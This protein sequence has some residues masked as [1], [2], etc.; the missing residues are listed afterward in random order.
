MCKMSNGKEIQL[1]ICIT[2]YNRIHELERC[3]LSIDAEPTYNVEVI[4]SED[5]S[6]K[7]EE[8]RNIVDN[9]A[10]S[11]SYRVIYNSNPHNLGYDRNLAKLISLASGEF[12]LLMSDDDSFVK[13]SLNSC[14]K[15]ISQF[16]SNVCMAYTY[17]VY[18]G[19]DGYGRKHRGDM[20]ID[21]G[22][23]SCCKYVYDAILFSGLIFRNNAINNFDAERFL[24]V[25]YFQV[26]LFLSCMLIHQT[27]YIDC[28]LVSC[29]G[30]G[31]NAYGNVESSKDEK[32]RQKL[33]DRK[34]VVSN[35]YFNKGLIHAIEEFD[36]ENKTD[37]LDSFEKEYSIHSY[38]GLSIA[39]DNGIACLDEYWLAMKQLN[40]HIHWQAKVYYCVLRVLGRRFSDT[41][42]GGLRK[43]ALWIR[44]SK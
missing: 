22:L 19:S 4:V 42:F 29:N 36:K 18:L 40:I 30:D 39:R 31:E 21:K 37:L 23:A 20:I 15:K 28:P 33:A 27:V 17:F 10:N 7:Q 3:L 44:E 1:S 5:C 12:I 14:I 8:I 2:S 16:D 9:Y 43:V 41:L 35:V 25:N 34:S 24:N 6:P 26:Y 13:G 32:N 11:S 38:T